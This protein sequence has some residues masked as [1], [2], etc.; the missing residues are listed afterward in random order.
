MPAGAAVARGVR[1]SPR[2]SQ[3]RDEDV[4]GRVP[5]L[6]GDPQ[7]VVVELAAGDR[8]AGDAVQ[9]GEIAPV[10]LRVERIGAR[11]RSRGS[12]PQAI[13]GRGVTGGTVRAMVRVP[14][15]GGAPP[16]PSVGAFSAAARKRCRSPSR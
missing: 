9:Q 7:Q 4:L 12:S 15:R 16:R 2:S 10:A 8:Q 13:A 3:H 14:P 6:T 5:H 1:R 11:E